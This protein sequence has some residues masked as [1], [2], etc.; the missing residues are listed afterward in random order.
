LC[1][2]F[3]DRGEENAKALRPKK[4]GYTCIEYNWKL[5]Y[6]V[7]IAKKHGLGGRKKNFKGYLGIC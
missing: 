5:R 6:D 2:C 4:A 7:E 1:K 3:P